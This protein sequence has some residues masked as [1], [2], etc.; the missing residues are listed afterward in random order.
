MT[1]DAELSWLH[2]RYKD[3]PTRLAVELSRLVAVHEEAVQRIAPL[4][5]AA[6]RDALAADPWLSRAELA[7]RCGVSRARISTLIREAECGG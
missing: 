3:D 6:L 4:R 5:I 1:S 2:V 7:R